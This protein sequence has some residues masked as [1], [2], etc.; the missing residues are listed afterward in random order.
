M[1][2]VMMYA[3]PVYLADGDMTPDIEQLMR[4]ASL[5]LTVPVICI[6]PRPS[7]SAPGATS[8]CAASAW[9]CRWR[10]ASARRLPPAL[11]ATLI[12]SGEVYF[13]SVTM[14]V[15]FLL[16]GRYLEM[17]ARQKAARSVETLA[18]AI[19][20]FAT[21]L[22]SWP[23]PGKADAGERVAVAEL[24][25]GD[26]VRIKPGETVPADGCVLDGESAA[27]ESC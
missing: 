2:Q 26:A 11:W 6:P 21:R 25:A 12:A 4:W 7:S 19:P 16:S 10:W 18:R 1:M 9:T 14:F 17:M 20:A 3:V 8:A 24:R 22:A 23:D 15:F 13:D 27:D 5:I